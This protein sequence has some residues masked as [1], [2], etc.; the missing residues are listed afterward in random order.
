MDK[1]AIRNLRSLKDTGDIE[2]KPITVLVGRNSSGKSTFL[3]SFPLLKQ[4]IETNTAEP[5]LWF[6]NY[7]DFGDFDTALSR[8]TTNKII[9]YK[10]VYNSIKGFFRTRLRLRNF[11]IKTNSSCTII[12]D[13]GEKFLKKAILTICNQTIEIEYNE[14]QDIKNLK[15]NESNVQLNERKLVCDKDNNQ[16]IPDIYYADL[17]EKN[18]YLRTSIRNFFKDKLNK[19]ILSKWAFN[20]TKISTIEK[21]ISELPFSDINT[22]FANI[23]KSK[24]LPSTLSKNIDNLKIDDS[25]F[26]KFNN[27]FVGIY[28]MDIIDCANR[29]MTHDSEQIKYIKPIRFNVERYYRI[30]GLNI[31]DIDSRG[32]N[33]PMFLH[34]LSLKE[35]TDFNKWTKNIFNLNFLIDNISGHVSLI[36]K[37]LKNDVTFNLAD[38]GYGYSQIL[39]IIILLWNCQRNKR[40]RHP[41]FLRPYPKN[42]T[43]AIEQPELHLHPEFQARVIDLF[44]SVINEIKKKPF[45]LKI[46]FETHSE[47]IVNRLGYLINKH[48]LKPDDV[49][50][51]I[52]NKDINNVASVDS[53]T[54]TEKGKLQNWPLGFFSPEGI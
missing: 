13:I 41:I 5:L 7:V 22:L 48:K 8:N 43:L 44:V 23:K 45:S 6:G 37:D 28:I 36:I 17:Y 46:I 24:N 33:I 25:D 35:R 3:R 18:I 39:P 32:E 42:I 21:F 19:F 54:F 34:S 38:V 47:T 10:F 15:I 40:K 9:Q 27:L 52:F 20:N 51:L 12:L 31:E 30:Q 4:S 26:E 50:V 49:N 2:L 16:V 53:A 14:K 29:L 11:S 1:I